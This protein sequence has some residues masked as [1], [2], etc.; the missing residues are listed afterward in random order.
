MLTR[1]NIIRPEFY[2]YVNGMLNIAWITGWARNI[3]HDNRSFMIQQSNILNHAIPVFVRQR[4][5]IP[6]SVRDCYPVKILAHMH[7]AMVKLD[8]GV[9]ENAKAKDAHAVAVRAIQITRPTSMEMPP[10]LAFERSLAKGASAD[11]FK[12]IET[13]E[14]RLGLNCNTVML[15][16]FVDNVIVEKKPVNYRGQQ[17]MVERLI[18]LL[19]QSADPKRAIEVRYYGKRFRQYYQDCMASMKDHVP[20]TISGSLR[21]RVVAKGEAK[22]GVIQ[23]VRRLPYVHADTFHGATPHEVHIVPEWAKTIGETIAV[24]GGVLAPASAVVVDPNDETGMNDGETSLL[25]KAV[26]APVVTPTASGAQ[27]V[28]L[29][30]V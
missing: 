7:G 12:P 23:D 16:G 3:D 28:S 18:V 6:S 13:S 2:K 19:R 4:D 11:T 24:G 22:E 17:V 5:Y 14:D 15:S 8:D 30:D 25:Q 26:S 10:R 29:Q 21:V 9:G 20:M 27:G 1:D